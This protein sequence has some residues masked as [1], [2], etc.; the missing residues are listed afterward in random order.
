M[1]GWQW[2]RRDGKCH[3]GSVAAAGYMEEA[4]GISGYVVTGNKK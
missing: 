4:K 3:S 2:K 1:K